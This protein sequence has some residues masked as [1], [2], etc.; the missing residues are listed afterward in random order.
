MAFFLFLSSKSWSQE[1]GDGKLEIYL[2]GGRLLPDQIDAVDETLGMIS[3]GLGW[4]TPAKSTYLQYGTASDAGVKYQDYSLGLRKDIAVSGLASVVSGG[5]SVIGLA[6]PGHEGTNYYLGGHFGGGIM[7]LIS[8][9]LYARMN[10]K[11]NV[12]PGVAM[13][14]GFGLLYRPSEDI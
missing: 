13:F 3:L 5:V 12:N 10:M 8:K 4:A 2:E 7:A 1:K 11:F 9:G 14:L 6:R